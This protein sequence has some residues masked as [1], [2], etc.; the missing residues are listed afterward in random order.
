LLAERDEPDKI[1]IIRRDIGMRLLCGSDEFNKKLEKIAKSNIS[2][3]LER[4]HE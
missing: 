4:F 3:I 2:E 1:E